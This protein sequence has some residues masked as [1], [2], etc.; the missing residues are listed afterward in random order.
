MCVNALIDYPFNL[1]IVNFTA[2]VSRR[3][4]KSAIILRIAV[5]RSATS[6]KNHFHAH[7]LKTKR[8]KETKKNKEAEKKTTKTFN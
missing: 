1:L 8:K 4:F 6:M 7:L 2:K 3:T 5:Y